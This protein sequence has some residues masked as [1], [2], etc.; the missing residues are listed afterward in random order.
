[1]AGL[2]QKLVENPFFIL[3]LAPT[4]TRAALEEEGQKLLGMLAL[5]LSAARTYATPLGPRERTPEL[6]R[7]AMAELRDPERRLAHELLAQSTEAAGAP[8][9][10]DERLAPWPEALR[11]L[12]FQR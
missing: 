4:C 2:T 11:A 9:A 7:T 12:G 5:G 1:M 10:S 3:G 8:R 6:V